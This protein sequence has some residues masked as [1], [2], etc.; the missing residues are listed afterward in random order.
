MAALHTKMFE[1]AGLCLYGRFWKKGFEEDLEL[2]DR[3][4]R[5]WAIDDSIVPDGVWQ[6]I[7]ALLND[8]IEMIRQIQNKLKTEISDDKESSET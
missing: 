8:R 4:I 7:N 1:E 6:D 2:G 3:T 5:R